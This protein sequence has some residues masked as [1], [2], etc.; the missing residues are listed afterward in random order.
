VKVADL[1]YWNQKAGKSKSGEELL[2]NPGK[3]A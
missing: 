2:E 3:T 1:E